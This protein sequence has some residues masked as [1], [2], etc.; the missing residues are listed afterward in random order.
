MY[1]YK[2]KK[3]MTFEYIVVKAT[4]ILY[5]LYTIVMILSDK[6]KNIEKC[7]SWIYEK[8]FKS[9]S[10]RTLSTL[11]LNIF[12]LTNKKLN[13]NFT[14]FVIDNNTFALKMA[15]LLATNF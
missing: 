11:W 13:K 3:G 1:T 9:I 4:V 5:I 15:L 7:S 8:R 12:F 2:E 10:P 14:K 6:K